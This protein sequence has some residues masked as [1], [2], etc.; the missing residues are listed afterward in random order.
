MRAARQVADIFAGAVRQFEAHGLAPDFV[1]HSFLAA[2]ARESV[3]RYGVD[4]TVTWLRGAADAIEADA[5]EILA[6]RN[7]KMN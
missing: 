1:V 3:L 7:A 2:A 4:A 6:R 5:A